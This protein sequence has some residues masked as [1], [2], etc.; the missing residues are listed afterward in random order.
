M[1]R[2]IKDIIGIG[3][4]MG[5]LLTIGIKVV[6]NIDNK[7]VEIKKETYSTQCDNSNVATWDN[8]YSW[9]GILGR[10]L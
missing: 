8:T 6:Q 10:R 5:A 3:L 2:L 4:F 1:I 9:S 7:R